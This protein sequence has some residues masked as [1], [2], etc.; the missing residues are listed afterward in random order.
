[1]T[2]HNPLR[3]LLCPEHLMLVSHS[4]LGQPLE[5]QVA[6]LWLPQE[7]AEP[8]VPPGLPARVCA[9]SRGVGPWERG[10]QTE[11][12][13]VRPPSIPRPFGSGVRSGPAPPA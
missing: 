8:G 13:E 4:F 7:G 6:R 2:P 11:V 1:M 9:L 12:L 3:C 5:S 10:G